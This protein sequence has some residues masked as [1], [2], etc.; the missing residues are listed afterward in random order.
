MQAARWPGPKAVAGGRTVRQA[1]MASGQRGWNLQPGGG[2]S[3]LPISPLIMP[4]GSGTS[5]SGRSTE[6]SSAR[7]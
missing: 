4:T 3:A 6:A 2:L 1:S 5:G 7:V